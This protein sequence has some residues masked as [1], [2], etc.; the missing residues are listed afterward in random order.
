MVKENGLFV[1]A[2]EMAKQHPAT[3]EVPHQKELDEIRCDDFV[4]ICAASERFWVRVTSVTGDHIEGI[5]D[6]VL[7][8]SD[9]HNLFFGQKVRFFK[10]HVYTIM[11]TD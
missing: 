6:N 1:D 10:H 8:C 5:V 11:E 7:I 9:E 4:K 3:F 2:Q